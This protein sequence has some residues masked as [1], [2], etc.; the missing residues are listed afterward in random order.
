MSAQPQT[1]HYLTPQEYLAIERC[2]QYKSEYF[3]GEM[4]TMAGASPAHNQITTKCG[5]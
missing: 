2:A 1:T 4:F 3:D 5:R